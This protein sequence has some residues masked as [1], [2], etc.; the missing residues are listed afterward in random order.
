[1][2]KILVID[3]DEL[4]RALYRTILEQKGYE[5]IEASGGD[6]GIGLF[7][8]EKPDLVITDIFMVGKDGLEVIEEL[9]ERYDGIKIIA[10]TGEGSTRPGAFN[11][12]EEAKRCGACAVLPKP[13]DWQEMVQLIAATLD[14]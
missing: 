7:H 14:N 2:E 6:E 12:L 8:S 4:S 10:I 11:F 3:D 13:I 5:V 9:C 1:M